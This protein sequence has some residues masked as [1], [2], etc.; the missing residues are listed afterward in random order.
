MVNSGFD[1]AF[2]DFRNM[3]VGLLIIILMAQV[4]KNLK[5][6]KT[7]CAVAF[8]G[9]FASATIGVMQHFQI[10]GM[11][12]RILD[13]NFTEVWRVP[14]M[15]ESE[16]ELSFT[17]PVAVLAVVGIYLTNGIKSSTRKLMLISLPV[18]GLALYFT[19]T[20]SAL[21]ALLLGLVALVIFI[22]TRTRSEIILASLL[23][24]VALVSVFGVLESQYLGGRQEVEQEEST[25]SRKIVWQAGMGII[26]DYPVL[27]IGADRFKTVSPLYAS[28][29]DPELL[30][31]E[32]ARY[33]SYRS[34]GTIAPHNDFLMVWVSYGTLALA[35][36]IWLL[37]AVLRN[38]FYSYRASNVRF[39]RG[40]SIGLAAAII[41]Y[42]ANAFYHNVFSTMP[43]FWILAGFSV[44][45][46]KLAQT[47]QEV[48]HS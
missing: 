42:G 26:A 46:A 3:L 34:L 13:P 14:G 38:F 15:A 10:L 29:V 40:L 43:L 22:K 9:M 17:L 28:E 4:T 11:G 1:V 36:Y 45:I 18:M 20:R 47:R 12:Q 30:E 6:L 37:F 25:V 2:T 31:W 5:D 48:N 41:A 33:W 21:F 35:A 39:I 23:V 44:T 8:A 7:L 19:Y 32:Q 16:L 27:G 24:A